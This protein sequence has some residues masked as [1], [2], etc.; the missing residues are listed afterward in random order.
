[1]ISLL[2]LIMILNSKTVLCREQS[3]LFISVYDDD[4][5]TVL[6]RELSDHFTTYYNYVILDTRLL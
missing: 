6:H 3:D 4:A 5:K 1:M 2:C